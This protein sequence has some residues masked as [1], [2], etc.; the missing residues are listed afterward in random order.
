MKLQSIAREAAACR[1]AWKAAPD[2]KYAWHLHHGKLIEALS[3]PAANRIAYI[4]RDKP[5]DE[6]ALR[7][8]LFR[9]ASDEAW[10]ATAPAW[11]AYDKATASARAAYDKA[12]ASA[13][14]AYTKAT[15]PARAAYTKA[16]APA[17][18]AECPDCSWDGESIFGKAA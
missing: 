10:Q 8:R 18:E 3:E 1:K 2:A 7:L 12:V 17:H 16:T 4:L 6:Q 11:A 15:A 13:R 14:A 5:K 9:P